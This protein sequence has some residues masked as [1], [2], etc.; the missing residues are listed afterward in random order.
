MK[1]SFK[2]LRAR[3]L[4]WTAFPVVLLLVVLVAITP[5]FLEEMARTVAQQ[6]DIELARI[7]AFRL[8]AELNYCSIGLQRIAAGN[9]LVKMDPAGID[10]LFKDIDPYLFDAGIILYDSHGKAVW[11]RPV[12]INRKG[13]LFPVAA[14]FNTMR[15]SMRPVFSDI[16][17]D[18]QTGENVIMVAVPI[19]NSSNEFTGSL[20]GLATIKYSSLGATYARLLE[21]KQ[22]RSGYAYLVDGSGRVIY[23]RD[24]SMVGRRIRNTRPVGEVI[25][26]RAGS[27][28][29]KE[30]SGETVIV[31]FAPVPLTHWGLITQETWD[32]IISPI[33]KDR[34]FL[35]TVLVLGGIVACLVTFAAVSRILRP[36]RDLTAGAQR[37]ASGDFN[38]RIETQTG[39]EVQVLSRQFNDMAE[40]LKKSYHQLEQRV[41]ER[42]RDLA[43]A[44][45][46]AI[47]AERTKSAFIASMSHELRT[48]LNS[49]IGF[50]GMVLKGVAGPLT[51]EQHK[52][53]TTAYRSAQHLLSLIND[54]LDLSKIE[55]G[56]L[57]ITKAEFDMSSLM[58]RVAET[59]APM[60]VDKK[61]RLT[62]SAQMELPPLF[63]DER[64]VEQI[65]LNIVNNAIKFTESG[66]IRIAAAVKNRQ[67]DISVTDTGVGIKQEDI[68]KLFQD[69]RQIA[70]DRQPRLEGTG[71]GLV[72]CDRLAKLLGGRMYV[73]S[74]YGKGSVF[75]L[76]LPIESGDNINNM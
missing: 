10:S 21:F 16:F 25:Q 75:G 47:H 30:D 35:L 8:S 3:T 44:K 28:V 67:M 66:E 41:D 50:T 58:E 15:T 12:A 19:I 39:D 56:R 51:D 29:L 23:H 22:G 42:T 32:V 1:L 7:S 24:T 37:I 53:L 76:T 17:N 57:T 71:L 4:L 6:R 69:Y 65:L 68:E 54:V 63:S 61:L 46:K 31:G 60:V 59:V 20:A 9:D 33:R 70:A 73:Q 26:G 14:E 40:T 64:R 62:V 36:I 45:E 55:A 34:L 43:D 74:T 49:I 5:R 18:D 52:Q 48:P 13:G 38:H 72:I 11:S 2:S 27:S